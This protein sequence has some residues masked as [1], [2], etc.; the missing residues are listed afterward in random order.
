MRGLENVAR[1]VAADDRND[2]GGVGEEPTER[3]LGA[4]DVVFLRQFAQRVLHVAFA[5]FFR[6]GFGQNASG[7]RR[8]GEGRDILRHAQI[9]R[10]VADVAHAARITVPIRALPALING[11][12][13]KDVEF[14]LM[15][16]DGRIEILLQ[17]ARLFG[18]KVGNADGAD[19]SGGDGLVQ[20]GGG[21]ARMRQRI[22]AMELVEV[23]F[24]D[25]QTL[26]RIFDGAGE[27][28]RRKIENC[29]VGKRT[30]AAFAPDLDALA[31]VGEGFEAFFEND[32]AAGAAVDVGVVEQR[33]AR[34]QRGFKGFDGALFDGGCDLRRVAHTR[35]AHA[36]ERDAFMIGK[37]ELF[38]LKHGARFDEE[39][40]RESLDS[41]GF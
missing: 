11:R 12:E 40:P 29:A 31:H 27:V 5:R 6:I 33:D 1:V 24:I 30:D 41:R 19:V 36:A 7:E 26:A 21:V 23:D 34:D 18:E 20:R 14:P 16:D 17:S 9:E 28:F 32:F 22:G 38:S 4:R 37:H 2:S 39:K 3:D 8:V 10:A 35:H 15:T 13:A 25:A